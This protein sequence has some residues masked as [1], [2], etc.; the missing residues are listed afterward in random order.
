M[1]PR[2]G[3]RRALVSRKA[4]RASV[5]ARRKAIAQ[6]RARAVA[7]FENAPDAAS[8]AGSSASPLRRARGQGAHGAPVAAKTTASDA[9]LWNALL[10]GGAAIAVGLLGRQI[11]DIVQDR[12][13]PTLQ[14]NDIYSAL[15]SIALLCIIGVFAYN[16]WRM[17]RSGR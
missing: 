6:R 14:Q 2:D 3:L 9:R 4:S 1:A 10:V 13:R 17:Q 12:A 11:V 15:G 7:A 16:R 5:A 8:P